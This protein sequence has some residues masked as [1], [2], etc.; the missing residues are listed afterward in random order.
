MGG[1]ARAA[2]E[3]DTD[4][5]AA[6][7][8][9]QYVADPG[10]ALDGRS[11]L[12]ED[13]GRYA[14]RVWSDKSVYTDKTVVL[15]ATPDGSVTVE[16]GDADFLTI[17]SALGSSRNLTSRVRLPLD[18]VFVID[19]SGS[20]NTQLG[21]GSTRI[22]KTIEATN[23]AIATLMNEKQVSK[24]SRVGVVI[25]SS[26][27]YPEDTD[28]AITILPLGRYTATK[29]SDGKPVYISMTGENQLQLSAR[30]DKGIKYDESYSVVGGTNTQMGIYQG[31]KMLANEKETKTVIEKE[32]GKPEDS[33]TV[34]RIPAVVLLSD[35]Q[36]TFSSSGSNWW[37]PTEN[38]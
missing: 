28:A 25:F 15:N 11:I 3:G 2:E 12:G 20:M 4:P 27:D 22:S 33:I 31:M 8:Q 9:V 21:D 23:E 35:G 7:A 13:G 36:P 32:S 1:L 16:K 37:E 19:V 10:T 26:K 6:T 17:F 5:Q 18:V 34:S 29:N 30:S 38:E 24:Y 14:G